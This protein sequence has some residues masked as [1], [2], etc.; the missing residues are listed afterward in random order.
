MVDP[1]SRRAH[2]LSV[3]AFRRDLPPGAAF[4]GVVCPKHDRRPRGHQ[5]PDRQPSENLTP[6]AGLPDGPVED[7]IDICCE[8]AFCDWPYHPQS[9]CDR[10]GT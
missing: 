3:A 5:K 9:G 2:R 10:A 4:H 8:V 7:T 6:V 1:R